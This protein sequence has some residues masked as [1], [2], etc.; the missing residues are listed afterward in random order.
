MLTPIAWELTWAITSMGLFCIAFVHSL[1]PN[2]VRYKIL[3]Q[4]KDETLGDILEAIMGLWYHAQKETTFLFNSGPTFASLWPSLVTCDMLKEYVFVLEH[5][6]HFLNEVIHLFTVG[7][8]W[9]TSRELA[10]L[11]L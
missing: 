1:G 3:V 4:F 9:T 6:L 8:V 11:I 5:A 2:E 7:G 10:R